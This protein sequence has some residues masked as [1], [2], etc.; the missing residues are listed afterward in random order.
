MLCEPSE[1]VNTAQ[2]PLS[3]KVNLETYNSITKKNNNQPPPTTKKAQ[4][5]FKEDKLVLI[6][7]K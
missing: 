5:Y 6:K 3:P 1:S 7:Q 4:R 2:V